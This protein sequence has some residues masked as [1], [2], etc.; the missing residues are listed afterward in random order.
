MRTWVI[1]LVLL[2]GGCNFWPNTGVEPPYNPG[3]TMPAPR[4]E[5]PPGR[6]LPPEPDLTRD[7]PS[8]EPSR[9]EGPGGSE[10]KIGRVY[11]WIAWAPIDDR[12]NR[13]FPKA[14]IAKG[15]V[16]VFR[17]RM[18]ILRRVRP[19]GSLWSHPHG[20]PHL[21]GSPMKFTMLKEIRGLPHLAKLADLDELREAVS[22]H[23]SEFGEPP[24]VYTGAIRLNPEI[25][26][27]DVRD[28]GRELAS[29]GIE[30]LVIDASGVAPLGSIDWDAI[31]VL[32]K[33][34]GFRIGCE[35]WPDEGLPSADLDIWVLDVTK[36]DR[37]MRAGKVKY[38]PG[39]I[40]H[41]H[42]NFD[43]DRAIDQLSRGES[44]AVNCRALDREG[45]TAEEL[46]S[47]ARRRAADREQ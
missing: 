47:A 44:I 26:L 40:V 27:Q 45:I 3:Q 39:E 18:S 38:P 10:P 23:I 15:H 8:R 42:T 11:D 2:L 41:M 6:E 9:P 31:D 43:L 13:G 37:R 33:E 46:K 19:D 24:V 14:T 12:E 32:R 7:E 16:G 25:T 4:T 21:K 22:M 20:N 29:C 35:P 5:E 30:R 28:Y 36:Y 34:F 17:E 1:A